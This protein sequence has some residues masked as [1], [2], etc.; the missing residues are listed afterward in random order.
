[1]T[2]VGGL[3]WARAIIANCNIFLA[4][5]KRASM[6]DEEKKQMV[7]KEKNDKKDQ[8]TIQ[9]R[10]AFSAWIEGDLKSDNKGYPVLNKDT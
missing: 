6:E 9:T 8:M 2:S 10:R 7:I 1:M 3:F 5:S 4:G